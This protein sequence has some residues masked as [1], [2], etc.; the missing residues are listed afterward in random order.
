MERRSQAT[1]I[2]AYVGG[3]PQNAPTAGKQLKGMQGRPLTAGIE[4]V[5]RSQF[6]LCSYYIQKQFI[7]LSYLRTILSR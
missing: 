6:T 4:S 5:Y 3:R 7:E 1:R 2:R